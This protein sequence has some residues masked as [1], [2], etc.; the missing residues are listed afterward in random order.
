MKKG[1]QEKKLFE[2]A[3]IGSG[4][5][6]PQKKDLFVNGIYPFFRTADAGRIKKGVIFEA[7]DNLNKDGIKGL[8]LFKKGTILFPKSGAST[9]LNHRVVL[10]VDGCVSSH[11]ATIKPDET[12]IDN[13]FLYYFLIT[14]DA[15]GLIQDKA[16]PSLRLSDISSIPVLL[17]LLPEQKRIVSILDKVFADID[18]VKANAEQNLK[19][20]KELFEGCLEEAY[21]E[22]NG[23]VKEKLINIG[24]VKTGKWDANHAS[25]IGKYRFYTCAYDF[26][27]CETYNFS[28]EC[29]ILPG[30]GVNVGEVFYYNGDFDAYQRTYVISGIRIYPKFLYFHMFLNWKR[31][32][33]KKQYGAATNFIKIGN[34]KGY[35][36]CFPPEPEQ[37]KIVKKI[38][39][40]SH[41]INKL[42]NI[43]IN[44]IK[45]LEELKKS[46][47]KK[48]FNGEI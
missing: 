30:N 41:K 37:R 20:I 15:R 39:D 31:L 1:W 16:Y 10:G 25:E 23:W 28:G 27:M 9:F 48:A 43:Y 38:E 14:I 44:K 12:K 32:G 5:S 19:N 36:V 13:K 11:L 2:I 21:I 42:K 7:S 34:F 46:I 3:D 22:K 8:R 29:L 17:P 18:K 24:N 26:T 4:N 47:L 40:I 33:T 35:E 45:N 6:A